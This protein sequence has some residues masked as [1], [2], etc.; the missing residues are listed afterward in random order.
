MPDRGD[1]RTRRTHTILLLNS[2]G[3]RRER[4]VL[5]VY[6][7]VSLFNLTRL[8]PLFYVQLFKIPC[9]YDTKGTSLPFCRLRSIL[10]SRSE[11]L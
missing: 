4:H 2:E 11:L 9:I 8:V 3:V 7:L 1:A 5:V 10:S 6:R